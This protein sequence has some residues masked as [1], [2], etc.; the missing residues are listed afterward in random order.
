[1]PNDARLGFEILQEHPMTFLLRLSDYL[2][3]LL[4]S[5]QEIRYDGVLADMCEPYLGSGYIDWTGHERA[6]FWIEGK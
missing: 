3:F 1:M 4:Y 6:W 5:L 2:D